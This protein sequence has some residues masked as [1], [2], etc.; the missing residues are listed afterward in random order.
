MGVKPIAKVA[1]HASS[2]AFKI[3]LN[4]VLQ[5]YRMWFHW[6]PTKFFQCRRNK[7]WSNL[8]VPVIIHAVKF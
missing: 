2:H 6:Q 7:L 3:N 8:F 4:T 1:R 5:K